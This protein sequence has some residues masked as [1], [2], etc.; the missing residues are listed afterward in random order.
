MGDVWACRLKGRIGD[1]TQ[2]RSAYSGAFRGR[3][4][5]S[6]VRRLPDKEAILTA[7]ECAKQFNSP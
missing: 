6:L 4:E 1:T 5:F 7:T 3:K 2:A